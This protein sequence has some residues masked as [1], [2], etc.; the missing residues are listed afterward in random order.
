MA[1]LVVAL[2]FSDHFDPNAI[3]AFTKILKQISK[4]ADSRYA[5]FIVVATI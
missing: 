1:D 5:K 3:A 4:D 2:F